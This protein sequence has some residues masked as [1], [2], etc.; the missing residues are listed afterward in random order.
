MHKTRPLHF[1]R[2]NNGDSGSCCEHSSTMH[3]LCR[4]EDVIL[5]LLVR[6]IEDQTQ[7]TIRA[8]HERAKLA[9]KL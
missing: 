6:Y 9:R 3:I 8:L 1:P 2:N 4:K 5:R 7:Y